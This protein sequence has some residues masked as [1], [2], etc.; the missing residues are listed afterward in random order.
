L[1]ALNLSKKRMGEAK[2]LKKAILSELTLLNMPKADF[3]ID[4]T[5]QERSKTGADRVEF[6][7]VPNVGE[8]RIPIRECAS[9]G[10]LSRILLTIQVLLAGKKKIPTLVFDEIDANIGGLTAVVVGE[11]LKQIGKTTQVLSVTH[12]QQVAQFADRHLQISKSEVEGRTLTSITLLDDTTRQA[13]LAR[14]AG[15]K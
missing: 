13:E 5:S 4:I 12:F 7:L 1:D 8:H 2:K 6:F 10:E 15:V 14:M 9:G 11:K 3:E